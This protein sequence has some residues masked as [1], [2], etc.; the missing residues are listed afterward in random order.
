M[1]QLPLST[2]LC[3]PAVRTHPLNR[4][5]FAYQQCFSAVFLTRFGSSNPRE[6]LLLRLTILNKNRACLD[7]VA[8]ELCENETISGGLGFRVLG[9]PGGP[10]GGFIDQ[11]A[12]KAKNISKNLST[13]NSF[14]WAQTKIP[15]KAF[16]NLPTQT[17]PARRSSPR[18]HRGVH[19]GPREAGG[20]LRRR[21]SV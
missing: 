9:G 5:L 18:A 4:Q 2:W 20:R 21:S 10:G 17:S 8:D 7:R 19:G 3:N 16:S 11:G 1:L 13:C 6:A 12:R 15:W 14:F